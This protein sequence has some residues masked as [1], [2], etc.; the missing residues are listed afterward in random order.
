MRIQLLIAAQDSKYTGHLSSILAE[1]HADAIN[2]SVCSESEHLQEQF[3]TRKFD[4]ALMEASMIEGVDLQSVNL[5]LILWSEE[6]NTRDAPEECKKIR[7]YQRISRMVSEML[8]MYAKGAGN[9]H[10]TFTKKA[11]ITAVWSPMGGVG[12]TTAALAYSAGKASFGKQV[13][14]L[15]LE[16]FSSVQ[17]YFEET[18]KSISAVFE[19]LETGEGNINMLIRGI[20]Q[21]DSASEIAYFCRP[22]N[23]DDMNIL[24]PENIAELISACSEVTDELVIDLSSVCD[25]RTRMVFEQADKILLVIDSSSAAQVKL[26]QFT[27]Q[28]DIFQQYKDKTALVA[29]KGAE[30]DES[31]VDTIIYFPLVQSADATAVYKTLSGTNFEV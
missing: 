17:T 21:Q 8:E 13:L 16:P 2:V 27:S 19:M 11:R 6:E 9:E 14:Y 23:F 7:K 28:H 15:D 4:I 25:E 5:P 30:I 22:E 26:S 29:N 12:K 31:P 1:N 3:M 18:G 10:G 24:T 20:R